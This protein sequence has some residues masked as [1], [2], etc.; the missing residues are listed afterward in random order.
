[1]AFLW[2]MYRDRAAFRR[3]A[4]ATALFL[5]LAGPVPGAVA[6]TLLVFGDSLVAGYGL[7]TGDAF[8]DELQR[9]LAAGGRDV[10]VVN[11]GVSGDTTAGGVSRIEWALAERPDAVVVVL[12]GNDALRG[13]A[14]GAMEENLDAIMAAIQQRGA[15]LLL[16]GMRAP[17]NM[18]PDFGEEFDAAFSNALAKAR[19]RAAESGADANGTVMFYPFFLDGVALEPGLNQSDGIH[20]NPDGVA[21]IT[22]RVLPYVE[23][24]LDQA[25]K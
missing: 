20:P 21:E 2:P 19:A 17:A 23:R 18:G 15:P 7:E 1:M 9:Q 13:L 10:E 5:M 6:Q 8:P 22:R 4:L 11:G 16:T 25:A 12:G 14:P 3:M 24:L